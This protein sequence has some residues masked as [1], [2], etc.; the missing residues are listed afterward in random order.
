MSVGEGLQSTVNSQLSKPLDYAAMS[1]VQ[2][3]HLVAAKGTASVH[4]GHGL[5][6]GVTGAGLAYIRFIART[7]MNTHAATIRN[8]MTVLMKLP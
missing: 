3:G 6:E 1:D 5:L 2:F 8:A 4:R 7:I